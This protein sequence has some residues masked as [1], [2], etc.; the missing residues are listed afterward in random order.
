M[1]FQTNTGE[2]KTEG[3][4][5]QNTRKTEPRHPDYTGSLELEREVINDLVA[6]INRGE[7]FGK[8]DLTGYRKTKK[9]GEMFLSITGKK[10]WVKPESA[11]AQTDVPP[12]ERFEDDKIPF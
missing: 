9:D 8:I 10:M 6:Q 1:P 5:W 12:M 4:M 3:A 7:R 2:W 11:N